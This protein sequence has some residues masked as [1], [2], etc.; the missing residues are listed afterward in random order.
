MRW[1]GGKRCP[2]RADHNSGV[3]DAR[4]DHVGASSIGAGNA[5]SNG[6]AG[7]ADSNGGAKN[8]SAKNGCSN[9][10]GSNTADATSANTADATSGSTADATSGST[11]GNG[12]ADPSAVPGGAASH[13]YD[14]APHGNRFHSGHVH[15]DATGRSA[16]GLVGADRCGRVR[17]SSRELVVPP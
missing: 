7:N 8:I 6:G 15:V 11:A 5:D 9:N 14:A 17:R 16:N 12:H 2:A 10:G 1:S 3:G 4:A 13:T